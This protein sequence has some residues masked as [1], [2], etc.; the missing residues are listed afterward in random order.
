[1]EDRIDLETGVLVRLEINQMKAEPHYLVS[2]ALHRTDSIP[3]CPE[4]LF[5][6]TG[7]F[8]RGVIFQSEAH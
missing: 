4:G 8:F 2:P 7:D 1:M 6:W 5:G 3:V